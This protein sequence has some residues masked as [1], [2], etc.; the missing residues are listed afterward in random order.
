MDRDEIRRLV[1]R[2]LDGWNRHDADAVAACY[3]PAAIGRDVGRAA[4]LP[5]RD[6]IRTSVEQYFVAFPDIAT[7]IKR[8][9][10][11]GNL[12]YVEWH[13][14]ATHQGEFLGLEGT[15]RDLET[16]GCIVFR[17]GEDGLFDSSIS[18]WD[19]GGL[20]RQLGP[21]PETPLI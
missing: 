11:D 5:D 16:D 8:F 17:V 18:Y 19:V 9:G 6:A 15:G 10:C 12:A 1:E 13:A 7:T 4:A 14:V 20:L 21:L 3:Q 2:W